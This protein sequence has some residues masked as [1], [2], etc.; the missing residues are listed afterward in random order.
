MNAGETDKAN[1]KKDQPPVVIDFDMDC[2]TR[3]TE[4]LFPMPSDH[5]H[6]RELEVKEKE[7]FYAINSVKDHS[8]KFVFVP[9]N[10]EIV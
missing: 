6:S 4:M 7:F 2:L 3:I 8:P 9:N 1:K 5:Q 10:I